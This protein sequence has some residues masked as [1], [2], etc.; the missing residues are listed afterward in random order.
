VALR[1]NRKTAVA[2]FVDG[3]EIKLAKISL[4][5]GRPV[6]EELRSSTLV[7]KIEEHPVAEGGSPS[8]AAVES[9][10][11]AAVPAAVPEGGGED[12]NA[13][14][15]GLLSPYPSSKYALGYSLAEPSIYYHTVEGNSDIRGRKLKAKILQ[16]IQDIR[17]SRPPMDAVDV[18]PNAEGGR[19]AV[20]REDGLALYKIMEGVKPFIGNRLP[21][22]TLVDSADL[23]L[24]SLIRA[25]YGLGPEEITVVVYIGVE[26]SRLIFLKGTEFFHFAPVI[27]EGYESPNIQN[28][29]YS[30]LL[31]EQD[32][33][34]I[35]RVD[36]IVIAGE[37]RR[38]N[39]DQFL[40]EQL[41]EL[42]IQY[43][44]VPYLDTTEVPAELFDQ[45]PEYAVPIATAWKILQEK[46]PAFYPINLIPTE[47]L[48]SQR[49]FKIA[50][51]GYILLALIPVLA[52]FFAGRITSQVEEVESLGKDL[53]QKQVQARGN[54]ELRAEI[55]EYTRQLDEF[56]TALGVYNTIVP[57]YD[58]WSKVILKLVNE[59]AKVNSVWITDLQV[60]EGGTMTFNGYTLFRS[61]VPMIARIF[62]ETTLRSVAV[63]E[64]RGKTVYK[65]QIVVKLP[66]EKTT[67]KKK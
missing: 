57:G 43:I 40:K 54:D 30:R 55:K 26:F 6:L 5:R 66:M 2:L 64:I 42:D 62:E 36:R 19:T 21:L 11:G 60:E 45:I 25:N 29:M 61:R 47:V 12:N 28:T 56:K 44:Q 65:F 9:D 8:E 49:V 20:V 33:I 17:E 39:F 32:S 1:R 15:L 34:G 24:I 63:D 37:A 10:F 67:D 52:F 59:F 3:Q 16:E 51:H 58:R 22:F 41:P 38:I 53:Q 27:G 18:F 4:K 48:E 14:L 35:P 50:W 7:A 13:I 31:L 23:S 46:H